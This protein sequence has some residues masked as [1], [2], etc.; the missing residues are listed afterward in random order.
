MTDSLK[1]RLA[2]LRQEHT[3][4]APSFNPIARPKKAEVLLPEASELVTDTG[5]LSTLRELVAL[6]VEYSAAERLARNKKAPVADSIKSICNDYSLARITCDRNRVSYY[7]MSRSVIVAQ[8]LADQG[9]SPAIIKACTIT[10]ES[11]AVRVTP[12]GDEEEDIDE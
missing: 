3:R 2:A 1:D 10:T 8:L 4:S 5:D 7:R 6:H 11:W 12:P 9:V